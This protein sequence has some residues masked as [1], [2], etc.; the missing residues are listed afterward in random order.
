MRKALLD[1]LPMD[2]MMSKDIPRKRYF[3]VAPIQIPSSFSDSIPSSA[4]ATLIH[5]RNL[6]QVRGQR[7]CGS[8]HENRA[9]SFGGLL[10]VRWLCSAT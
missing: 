5:L 7:P 6:A 4:G 10:M 2:L 9:L 3:K 8:L 1:H